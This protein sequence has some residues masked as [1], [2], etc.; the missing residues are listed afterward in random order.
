MDRTRLYFGHLFNWSVQHAVTKRALNVP[1][2]TTYPANQAPVM[3]WLMR[4]D[5][6]SVYGHV[7]YRPSQEFMDIYAGYMKDLVDIEAFRHHCMAWAEGT[8]LP[9]HDSRN[10]TMYMDAYGGDIFEVSVEGCLEPFPIP[11]P[12]VVI[13]GVAA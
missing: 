11:V 4:F 1:F 13:Q 6:E 5:A 7:Y 12:N 8:I 3:I 9:R 10:P 2:L